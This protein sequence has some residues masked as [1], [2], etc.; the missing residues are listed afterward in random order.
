MD[1][2]ALIVGAG[3]GI[4]AA[5]AR[6]LARDGYRVGLAARHPAKLARLKDEP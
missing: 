6:A 4:S 2:T 1:K 3:D 5:F